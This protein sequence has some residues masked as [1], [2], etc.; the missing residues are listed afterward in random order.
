M[1]PFIAIP[2]T[3]ALIVLLSACAPSQ[4][5][6]KANPERWNEPFRLSCQPVCVTLYP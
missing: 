6:L 3:I 1:P 2:L 4:G 5:L